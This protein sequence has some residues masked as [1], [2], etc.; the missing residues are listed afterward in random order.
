MYLS[1]FIDAGALMK[2]TFL[3]PNFAVGHSQ[4]QKRIRKSNTSAKWPQYDFLIRGY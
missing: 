3:N 4:G 1:A 2:C